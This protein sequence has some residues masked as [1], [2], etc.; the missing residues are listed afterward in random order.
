MFCSVDFVLLIVLIS[1]VFG[2][3]DEMWNC[4]GSWVVYLLVI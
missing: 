3:K 4:S 1:G 2:L